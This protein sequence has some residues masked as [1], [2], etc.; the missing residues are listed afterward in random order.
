MPAPWY[1]GSFLAW[2]TKGAGHYFYATS[3]NMITV[4]SYYGLHTV[5]GNIGSAMQ[6]P[7]Q[8]PRTSGAFGITMQHTATFTGTLFS[9]LNDAGVEVLRVQATAAGT[10][11]LQRWN[12]SSWV[13]VTAAV[14]GMTSTANRRWSVDFTGLGTALGTLRLRCVFDSTDGLTID[15]MVAGLNLSAISNVA[16]MRAYSTGGN[17]YEM[18]EAFI[19]DGSGVAAMGYNNQLGTAG[20]DADGTAGTITDSNTTSIDP[21]FASVP[22]VGSARSWRAAARNFGGRVV[23]AVQFEARLRRGTGPQSVRPYLKIGGTRYYHPSSPVALTASFADYAFLWDSNPATGA[24]WTEA[25]ANAATLE[26]GI[27]AAA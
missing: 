8:P 3:S 21:T 1:A 2:P 15:E 7:M 25:A 19:K 23:K 13:G 24:A 11:Q 22:N 9:A 5:N 17:S 4:R 16:Q 26:F 6:S 27:E 18:S 20:T 10:F 14:S 12:G